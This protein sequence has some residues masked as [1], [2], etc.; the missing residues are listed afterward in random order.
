[1]LVLHVNWVEASLRLWAESLEDYCLWQQRGRDFGGDD[2]LQRAGPGDPTPHPFALSPE[3][4]RRGL[5]EAELLGIEHLDG[6]GTAV[7]AL[8]AGGAAPAPSDRLAAAAEQMGRHETLRL[9]RFAVPALRVR[10]ECALEAMLR[11]EDRGPTDAVAFGHA[12]PF[13]IAVARFVLELLADQRFV[14]ALFQDPDAVL[15]AGWR[16]WL[17]DEAARARVDAL[18]EAMPPVVG[19]AASGDGERRRLVV[20]ILEAMCDAAVRRCLREQ[21]Y[22]AAID[23]RDPREDPQVAWLEGLLHDGAEV[24]AAP[25]DVEHLL[26]DANRWIGQLEAAGGT[27]SVRLCL[28]LEEPPEPW[29]P[30]AEEGWDEPWMLSAGLLLEGKP[31][32]FVAAAR[33]W[34]AAPSGATIDGHRVERPQE[35]L[36]AELGRASRIYPPLESALAEPQPS[37]LRL[38]PAEA[39]RFAREYR[40]LLEES[41]FAVE[42]PSWWDAPARRLGLRLHIEPLEDEQIDAG[43]GR[44]AAVTS[45]VSRL[46]L[47]AL[48]QFRWEIAVGDTALSAAELVALARQGTSLV[49]VGGRWVELD[50]DDVSAAV[51]VVEREGSGR[52]TLLRAIRMVCGRRGSGRELPVLGLESRGWVRDLLEPDDAARAGRLPQVEQPPDFV[53]WL[54]PYQLVGLRWL[55]FLEGFGLGA[56]L[57]DDMGLGK[58]IQLIALLLLERQVQPG[59]GATLLVVPTSLVA[60]W[61]REL[62]RFAPSLRWHV[63]HG[64]QRLTGSDFAA[65]APSA[66]VVITTYALVPRDLETLRRV[67]WRRVVLDEAQNIKNPPTRQTSAI[68]ELAAER[69]VALT[70]TPVENRLTELWSIMNFCN[71]DYLGSAEEFRRRYAVP[72]ERH[73]DP[74]R[75]EL[76]RRI[77]RPFV[78]RRLKTDPDVISDL[79]ACVETREYA[80]LTPEQAVLYQSVVDGLM[81]VM[82]GASPVQRRGRV[83]AALV[84]LKQVCNHPVHYLVDRDE[85]PAAL[86]PDHRPLSSRSGKCR[87]LIEMLEEVLAAGASALVF[88]Q[89][90]RMGHLL[91]AMIRHDLDCEV[92]FLHGGTPAPRRQELVDRFQR[93]DGTAPVLVLSLRAGGVG[94]NLTAAT[95]VFHFDRWW[96]PAVEAQATDRAF[97]IGQTRT[98]HVHKFVCVG[99][100]EERIDQMLQEKSSLAANV[101]GSGEQWLVDLS[102]QE[103]REVLALRASALESDP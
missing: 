11:L 102:T 23:G 26:R 30:A 22:A 43:A 74:Q 4:L 53:G 1:M 9:D 94:L 69:R 37:S 80:T 7:V 65:A 66:D 97:R 25:R 20:E 6:A 16:P 92:L 51:E 5:A 41:G 13:W 49:R 100:L 50:P 62:G 52:T 15:R 82:D 58:T 63:H 73:R 42:A 55:A 84:R 79:P 83:L 67:A 27:P 70:G 10:S 88:T 32:A 60:N 24:A 47:Q 101:I 40:P 14:P 71:P 61:T 64:P 93:R 48:V 29:D 35:M 31:P 44:G 87:R 89:F 3:A 45:A 33:V 34:A 38:S 95:H 59:A 85:I 36:L 8:P 46:G 75:A 96:N 98:V 68:R 76:L 19:V 56:C 12:V 99:T 21:D 18:A 77:V 17:Q 39:A 90:R 57:A 91:S 72:I 54:R 86:E 103:L 81:S 2:G 28:R 78:L